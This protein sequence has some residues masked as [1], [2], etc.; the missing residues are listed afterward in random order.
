M[1]RVTPLH[2]HGNEIRMT[3]LNIAMILAALSFSCA[4]V[5]GQGYPDGRNCRWSRKCIG[6]PSV[7]KV[8]NR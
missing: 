1:L 6:L 2:F 5:H 7:V 8:G 3:H 4:G